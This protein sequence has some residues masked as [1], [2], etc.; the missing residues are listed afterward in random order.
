VLQDTFDLMINSDLQLAQSDLGPAL[1]FL[2][3]QTFGLKSNFYLT[4]THT[5][6]LSCCPYFLWP[7]A[8]V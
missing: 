5:N 8:S 3:I 6:I 7:F 1:F 4:K 2:Q